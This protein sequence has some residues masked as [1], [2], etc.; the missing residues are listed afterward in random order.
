[1]IVAL[2]GLTAAN[3]SAVAAV[4]LGAPLALAISNVHR[5]D[6]RAGTVAAVV[7]KVATRLANSVRA[8]IDITHDLANSCASAGRGTISLGLG[9]PG[10]LPSG[11]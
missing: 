10:R 5:L 7:S 1:M 2:L 3:A 9:A 11:W 6:A 8:M 4:A